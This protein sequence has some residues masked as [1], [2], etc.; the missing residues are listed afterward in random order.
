MDELALAVVTGEPPLFDVHTGQ[1]LS[2]LPETQLSPGARAGLEPPR[3][4]QICGRKMGVQIHPMGWTA[5]C[6]K[7]GELDSGLLER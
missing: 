2:D 3:Y 4:C 6:T 5:K 1:D 7:H